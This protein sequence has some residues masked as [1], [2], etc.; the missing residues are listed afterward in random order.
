MLGNQLVD[1]PRKAVELTLRSPPLEDDGLAVDIAAL[2][3]VAHHPR[4]QRPGV[5]CADA[6]Q[7]DTV[8]FA[9]LGERAG[10][11]QRHC[12]GHENDPSEESHR[13]TSASVA[14]AQGV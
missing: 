10:V 11:Q 6:D 3:K 5:G 1:K 13:I 8:D 2:G 7:P 4:A 9:R 12:G 14:A